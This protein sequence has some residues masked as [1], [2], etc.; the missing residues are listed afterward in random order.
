MEQKFSGWFTRQISIGLENGQKLKDVEINYHLSVLKPL[1]AKWLISLYDYLDSPEGKAVVSNG[2]KK[3]GI[4]D[5]I[6]VGSNKLP[7]LDPF[8]DICTSLIK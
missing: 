1:Q 5:A 8:S 2:W 7:V 3:S 6:T 4:Y